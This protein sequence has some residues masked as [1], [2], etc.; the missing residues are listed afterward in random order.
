[1][2]WRQYL[3]VL[4]PSPEEQQQI[5]NLHVVE[6][7]EKKGDPLKVPRLV[8]HWAY[9]ELPEHRNK[10]VERVLP[11][12]FKISEESN[13]PK[14]A[15]RFVVRLERTDFVDLSS[16]NEVTL[17]LFRLA[18]AFRGVYDGWETSVEKDRG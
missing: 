18:K 7:L 4:Y 12:G 5:E 11:L 13:D 10:F 1:P 9:F 16:I 17:E 3:D 6:E 15:K 14:A 8:I 2:D